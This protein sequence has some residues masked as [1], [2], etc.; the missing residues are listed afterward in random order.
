MG[1][2]SLLARRATS[3]VARVTGSSRRG[4][5]SNI[6][7]FPGGSIR[8]CNISCLKAFFL[9]KN[10]TIFIDVVYVRPSL[11]TANIRGTSIN[12]VILH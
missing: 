9:H 1:G 11:Y 6:I 4:F 2:M 7:V 8:H 3:G 10:M 12:F 5:I